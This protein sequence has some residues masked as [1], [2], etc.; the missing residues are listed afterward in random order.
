LEERRRVR[1]LHPDRAQTIIPGIVILT[2][3]MDL[4]GLSEVEVSEH[5]L[6]RGA[7]L[8]FSR[9]ARG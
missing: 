7:A 5:D 4:F 8:A 9:N 6:L 3:A 1:G 2:E